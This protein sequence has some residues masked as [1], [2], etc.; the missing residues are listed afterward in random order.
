MPLYVRAGAILPSGPEMNYTDERSLDLLTLDI[1]PNLGGN[2]T[3][4]LYEDDG[5]SFDYERGQFCTTRY[6]VL[7]DNVKIKIETGARSGAYQPSQRK[8]V[9]RIHGIEKQQ[10]DRLTTA[11]YD[12]TRRILTLQREDDGRGLNLEL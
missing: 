3:F 10:A 9:L 2:G 7:Q 1:Y 11:D 6:Q 8:L 4:T 12:P 5:H